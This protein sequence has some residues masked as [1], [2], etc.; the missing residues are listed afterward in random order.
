VFTHVVPISLQ[1]RIVK[2]RVVESESESEGILG[3]VRVGLG[4]GVGKKCTDSVSDLSL[5][6]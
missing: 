1:I 5:K 6:S 4:V 2:T 3:G